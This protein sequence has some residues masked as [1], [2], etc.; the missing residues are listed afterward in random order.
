[1]D[2]LVLKQRPANGAQLRKTGHREI[3]VG[4]GTEPTRAKNLTLQLSSVRCAFPELV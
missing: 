2:I 3:I 4:A 1:M